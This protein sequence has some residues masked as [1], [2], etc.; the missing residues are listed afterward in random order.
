[1]TRGVQVLSQMPSLA[2]PQVPSEVLSQMLSEAPSQRVSR[3]L[4]SLPS[5]ARTQVRRGNAACCVGRWDST[6]VRLR[7]RAGTYHPV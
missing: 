2:P 6:A 4:N 1:M 3:M 7:D 5:L